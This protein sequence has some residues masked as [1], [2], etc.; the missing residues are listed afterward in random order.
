MLDERGSATAATQGKGTPSFIRFGVDESSVLEDKGL[1]R[2][3][4]RARPALLYHMPVFDSERVEM[5]S[6]F[7]GGSAY[8]IRKRDT[9]DLVPIE[10]TYPVGERRASG[11]RRRVVCCRHWLE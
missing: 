10:D 4:T 3:K 9:E 6:R 2:R 1:E 5:R 11:R 8:S 7:C